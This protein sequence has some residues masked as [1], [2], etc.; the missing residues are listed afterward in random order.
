MQV[1]K[2]EKQGDMEKLE[3]ILIVNNDVEDIMAMQQQPPEGLRVFGEDQ[4][5]ARWIPDDRVFD[6][7][8]IDND[9]ND[10]EESMGKDTLLKL[11]ENGFHQPVIY[12]SFQPG[13]VAEEVKQAEGVEVVPTDRALEVIADRYGL[14]LREPVEEELPAE[15]FM[16]ILVTYNSVSGWPAD[17]YGNGKLLVVSFDKAASRDAPQVVKQKLDQIYGQ[18]NFRGRQDR[19]KIRNIFVYDGIAGGDRPGS[20]ASCLGHDARMRVYLMACGCDWPR[21]ER[22]RDSMYV[23]LFKVNCGGEYE[24]GQIADTIMGVE[25]AG[26]RW[27]R[28]EL[29]MPRWKILGEAEKHSI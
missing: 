9:A 29:P 5:G 4:R 28:D 19:A 24:L 2:M 17:I 7:I 15:S 18:F 13:W 6:L 16:N 27:D 26:G 11:R 12:T 8:V 21:K 20:A 25:R 23:D 14:T 10:R 1:T 3:R 22:L